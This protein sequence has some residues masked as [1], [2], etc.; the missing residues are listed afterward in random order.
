MYTKD[1]LDGV[2]ICRLISCR[3]KSRRSS[4]PS[5][6]NQVVDPFECHNTVTIPAVI[7]A[8]PTRLPGKPTFA[9][10]ANLI[11]VFAEQ[12]LRTHNSSIETAFDTTP[13]P[14]LSPCKYAYFLFTAFHYS[15]STALY[16]LIYMQRIAHVH[17]HVQITPYT[18]HR[19][20]LSAF[21]VASKYVED[22]CESRQNV[23]YVSGV[24]VED[25]K[26]LEF[27]FLQMTSFQLYVPQEVF[28]E[29]SQL[30]SM[31]G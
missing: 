23:A 27:S 14:V 10:I 6:K 30:A 31:I 12:H 4:K 2:G 13:I 3:R 25:L 5:H 1:V 22:H 19:L 21:F 20:I 29:Y 11:R 16:T 9:G 15:S 8:M 17:T 28:D 26:V 18:I 24:Q 7:V